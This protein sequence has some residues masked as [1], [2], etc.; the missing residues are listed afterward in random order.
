MTSPLPHAGTAKPGLI[1]YANYTPGKTPTDLGFEPYELQVVPRSQRAPVH[2]VI[3]ATGIT[4][5]RALHT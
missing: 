2:Y 4:M 3:T 1:L 5:V